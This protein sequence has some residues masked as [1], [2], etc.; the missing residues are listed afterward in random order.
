MM[1]LYGDLPQAKD[2]DA[3]SKGWASASKKLQPTFRPKQAGVSSS[4]SLLAV[5]PSVR[6]GGAGRTGGR[7]GSSDGGRGGGRGP[8]P[9]VHVSATAG[10]SFNAAPAAVMPGP[11]ASTQHSSFSFLKAVNGEP[12]KDEYD[13]SKP[14]DYE[15]IMRER[16]KRKQA[17]EEEAERAARLREA[18][19]EIERRKREQAEAAAFIAAASKPPPGMEAPAAVTTAEDDDEFVYKGGLGSGQQQQHADDAAAGPGPGS[20]AGGADDM[21]DYERERQ[22]RLKLSG[23]EAFAARGRLRGASPAGHP[24]SSSQ[25]GP[26]GGFGGPPGFNAP[27]QGPGQPGGA[28]PKGMG[29]AQKLL[30][31]MGWREGQGLGRNRQGMATPLVAQKTAAHAGVIVNA[32]L[33]PD[34]RPRLQGAAFNGP[35]TQVLVLRNMV[36]PGEVDEDL[37]EEVGNELTKYG[38]VEDVMIFEVTTPGYAPEEAVRIFIKFDRA[39]AATRALV[40]LQGRFFAGRQVRVAFFSE[41]RFDKQQLAPQAGEFGDS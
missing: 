27:Q 18:E 23:D 20:A 6:A 39:E 4:S 26:S 5:P 28:A 40:D 37:E 34:K 7:S 17:A 24:P 38:T 35:P 32:E 33:P 29:L 8:P 13:P 16:E 11:H 9:V 36:G 3:A 2:E 14:N 30:E 10:G 21:D 41:D 15:E 31:K 1:S 19:Q 12:L 25:P 22:R